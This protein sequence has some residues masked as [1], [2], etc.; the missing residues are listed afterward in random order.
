MALRALAFD[1]FGTVVD[2]RGT[3]IREG[4]IFN[5]KKGHQADWSK[6]ADAWRAGYK[7]AM[8]RVLRGE[9]RWTKLDVIHR[10]ILDSVLEQFEIGN[11][12]E[13]EIDHLNRVWHRLTPWPDV[14]PGLTR[15]RSRYIT[16][17]LSNGNVSMLVDMNKNAA[18]P[19]D[20]VL[21][22]E[23]AHSYKPDPAVYV[24]AAELLSIDPTELMMVAAH[25]DDLR[26]A[27][28][29]GL[30][31][32]FVPRPQEYGPGKTAPSPADV[33]LDYTAADF[34]DLAAQLGT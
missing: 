14:V 23:N 18:L 25:P 16:A 33:H 1:I 15:L 4:A 11:L 7:P 13:P 30:M 32:A 6:L 9:L 2:W 20:C 27:H 26:A 3:I 19:F 5:E 34:V 10:M 31:T 17:T 21:S 12:T 8:A 28:S 22:A 24:T 29:A